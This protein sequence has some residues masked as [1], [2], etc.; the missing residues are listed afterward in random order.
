MKFAVLFFFLILTQ[1]FLLGLFHFAYHEPWRDEVQHLLLAQKNV[2][3][4]QLIQA[5]RFEGHP[6][7]LH[8]IYQELLRVAEPRLVLAIVAAAGY[9]ALGLATFAIAQG[10]TT[11]SLGAFLVSVAA[12]WSY[13]AVYELGVVSRGYGLGM[14]FAVA[15]LACWVWHQKR[16]NAWLH[17]LG[18]L[19]MVAAVHTSVHAAILSCCFTL[20][21]FIRWNFEQRRSLI[22]RTAVP[23]GFALICLW[24]IVRDS[25]D[26]MPSLVAASP[27]GIGEMLVNA[28]RSWE[29]GDHVVLLMRHLTKIFYEYGYPTNWWPTDYSLAFKQ[30]GGS[31]FMALLAI[32]I[33]RIVT[34]REYWREHFVLLV[35]VLFTIVF[36]DFF[37]RYLYNGNFRHQLFLLHPLFLFCVFFWLRERPGTVRAGFAR[38]SLHERTNGAM[39]YVASVCVAILFVFQWAANASALVSDA[40]WPFSATAELRNFIPDSDKTRARRP[41]WNRNGRAEAKGLAA[42]PRNRYRRR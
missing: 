18:V 35:G 20:P 26:R 34:V 38:G 28:S 6:P 42:W 12:S 29:R 3:F 13:S 9:F 33:L 31:A 27:A 11:N 7:L 5:L 24:L 4:H 14:A 15:G 2:R 17:A 19:W 10:I 41:S 36:Y 40:R 23:M 32:T 22:L 16:P 21:F 25:P 30:L 1:S 8:L 37:L 39:A